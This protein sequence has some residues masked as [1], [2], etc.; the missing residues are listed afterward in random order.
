MLLVVGKCFQRFSRVFSQNQKQSVD[1][2]T[3]LSSSIFLKSFISIL[4]IL[5]LFKMKYCLHGLHFFIQ[6]F[7]IIFINSND[8]QLL[9]IK[10]GLMNRL[11]GT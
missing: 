8:A 11:L 2:S 10:F 5:V 6:N 3:E 9:L 4:C 7:W 1:V